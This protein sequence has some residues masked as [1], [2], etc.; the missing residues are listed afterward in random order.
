MFLPVW[1]Q[2]VRP[3]TIPDMNSGL[4]NLFNPIGTLSIM[5]H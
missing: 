4:I 5:F 3:S 2:L 1:I